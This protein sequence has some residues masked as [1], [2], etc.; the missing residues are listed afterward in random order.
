MFGLPLS[1]R[2]ITNFNICLMWSVVSCS[3]ICT[4]IAKSSAVK[5]LLLGKSSAQQSQV[6][7]LREKYCL[8]RQ[9]RQCFLVSRKKGN[10]RFQ[11]VPAKSDKEG[12]EKATVSPVI[13]LRQLPKPFFWSQLKLNLFHHNLYLN[14]IHPSNSFNLSLLSWWHEREINLKINLKIPFFE[15]GRGPIWGK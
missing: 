10:Y 6:K 12:K 13:H 4:K 14:Q 1:C 15:W 9:G 2:I 8:P 7:A 11:S 3:C 5:V